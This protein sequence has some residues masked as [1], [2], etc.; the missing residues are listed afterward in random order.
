MNIEQENT[1]LIFFFL[2][3]FFV[4]G[5]VAALYYL[6]GMTMDTELEVGKRL[7]RVRNIVD[8][9]NEKVDSGT[10]KKDT[11]NVDMG[12][13][14]GT[15]HMVDVK[16]IQRM[17]VDGHEKLVDV[18]G[19]HK[20]YY[21]VYEVSTNVFKADETGKPSKLISEKV[22]EERVLMKDDGKQYFGALVFHP[23]PV[24]ISTSTEREMKKGKKAKKAKKQKQQDYLCHI[25]MK[26]GAFLDMIPMQT[27]QETYMPT[28]DSNDDRDK[29]NNKESTDTEHQYIQTVHKYKG[30]VEVTRAL[31]VDTAYTL[32]GVFYANLTADSDSI[33]HIVAYR[34]VE[35]YTD[36]STLVMPQ[37]IE[38][39]SLGT[40]PVQVKQKERGSRSYHKARQWCYITAV[41]FCVALVAV[42]YIVLMGKLRPPLPAFLAHD[43]W[44]QYAMQFE[45]WWTI[46]FKG[47][48]VRRRP[49]GP[50]YYVL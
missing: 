20:T 46:T 31:L 13:Y 3:L 18:C 14:R 23:E 25:D 17:E 22:T 33:T 16:D 24:D 27:I 11:Y 39:V 48:E 9:F 6:D 21:D 7:A 43:T 36:I 12:Y 42:T 32:I 28:N 45:D 5:Y 1:V 29:S 19:V 30:T 40:S 34:V 15:L 26:D 41:M 47:G 38:Y 50:W 2:A 35:A 37:Y 8:K 44:D 10:L 4:S 49:G